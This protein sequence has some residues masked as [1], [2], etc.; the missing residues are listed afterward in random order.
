MTHYSALSSARKVPILQDRV[1]ELRPQEDGSFTA[2]G[3]G[4]EYS[5]RTVV[6]ATGGASYPATGSTGDGYTMAEALGHTIVPAKPSLVPLEAE[7]SFCAQ[8]Q[9]LALKNV[10][11][12]VK[13]K[14]KK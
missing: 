8:M 6:L 3:E 11:L 2:V 7:E 13:N 10:V 1:L 12:K 5:A 14:R 9:G 4:G